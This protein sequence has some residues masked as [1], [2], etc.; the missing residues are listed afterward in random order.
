MPVIP[1]TEAVDWF[2]YD[3][4]SFTGWVTKSDPYAQ[5]A[6]YNYPDWGQVLL[7]LAPRSSRAGR[8]RAS[9]PA[10]ARSGQRRRT[11][12]G[13]QEERH[14]ARRGS[15]SMRFVLRRLGFFVLTLWAAVT[16]NFLLPRLMPGNPALA[17]MGK[18]KGAVTPQALKALEAQFGLDTHQSLSR[19]TSTTSATWPP[20]TSG[21][22]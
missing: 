10:T 20:A 2:Q 15:D 16:L 8:G 5:P 17:V 21:C 13:R 14:E 6:A 1:V 7:H 4:G 22:R 19:S 9:C 3:T 18:F 12:D 11:I